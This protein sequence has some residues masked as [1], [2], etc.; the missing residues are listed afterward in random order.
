MCG[1]KKANVELDRSVLA[2]IAVENNQ[3]FGQ[4]VQVA[5][6]ALAK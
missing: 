1:L 2:N 4:L 6:Q 5:K 3:M